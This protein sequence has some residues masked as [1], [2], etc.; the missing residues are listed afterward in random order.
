M[1]KQEI[2]QAFEDLKLATL[3][4]LEV[5]QREDAIKLEKIAKRKKLLDARNTV[6]SIEF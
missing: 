5:S 1:N 4:Y 2:E 3:D 6:A